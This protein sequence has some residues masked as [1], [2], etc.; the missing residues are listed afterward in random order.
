VSDVPELRV[1]Q[2]EPS[3]RRTRAARDRLR[4]APR[5][6]RGCGG[7]KGD[8]T[9]IGYAEADDVAAAIAFARRTFPNRSLVLYGQSMGAAAVL[10]AVAVKGV[11][12]DA[13]IVESP[14]DRLLTTVEHRFDAMGL[15]S[16][17]LARLLVFWGGVQHGYWGFGHNPAE[18][19]KAVRLPV[20]VM[21]GTTDARVATRDATAI[22]DNLA[23]PKQLELF[24]GAA[25]LA[26]VEFDRDRWASV[27]SRFLAQHAPQEPVGGR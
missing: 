6:F 8:S 4:R 25:H 10:R 15:P 17:P 14:F 12:A 21:H 22:Y 1:E 7:S 27:V 11:A 3:P 9:T 23:G 26:F 16:F 2:V 19:A 5:D 18:Y 20:L 24:D 13:I